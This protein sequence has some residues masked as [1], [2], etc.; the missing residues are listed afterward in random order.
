MPG[1][2]DWKGIVFRA[3]ATDGNIVLPESDDLYEEVRVPLSNKTLAYFGGLGANHW[4]HRVRLDTSV[5]AAFYN[6]RQT[7]GLLILAGNSYAGSALIKC[8][9]VLENYTQE[10]VFA[11]VDFLLGTA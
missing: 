11:D 1:F 6:T 9:K 7:T 8:Q 3:M 10:Y 2:Y 4:R 5:Y